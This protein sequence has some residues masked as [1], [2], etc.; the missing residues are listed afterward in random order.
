MTFDRVGVGT[1]TPGSNTLQVGSGTSMFAI[2][3]DGG[4]GLG[5]TANGF[6]LNV[7]GSVFVG[8]GYTIYGDGSGIT[9]QDSIWGQDGSIPSSILKT[10]LTS[11][12]EW[13]SVVEF[14][15]ALYRWYDKPHC[16]LVTLYLKDKRTQMM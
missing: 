5:T 6:K 13:V 12:L 3:G 15:S 14:T 4:V 7:E 11:R 2:D 9:N 16:S 10:Q 1:T 8:A